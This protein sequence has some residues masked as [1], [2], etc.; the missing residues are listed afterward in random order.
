MKL[1]RGPIL[2][3]CFCCGCAPLASVKQVPARYAATGA[4]ELAVAEKELTEASQTE[5]RQ[6]ML[7][8]ADDLSGAKVAV[9]A[10]DRARD[11]ANAEKLY[12]FA[13]ARTVEII[14]RTQLAP[15]RRPTN[16]SDQFVLT[17]LRPPDP[18]HDPSNYNLFS[19]DALR[20]GGKFFE[21]RSSID[22]I[23]AP[24]VA[25][26]RSENPQ[27]R[28]RFEVPRVY[29]PTTAV[30]KFQGARAR[31]EFHEPFSSD[32][33]TIDNHSFPLAADYD[34]PMAMFLSRERPEKLGFIRLL[35][36]EKYADTARLTRLQPFDPGRTPVIFVH[37]LQETP[38]EWVPMISA[39]RK[40]PE[41]QRRYQLWVFSYPSGY[42]YPYSAALLRR[43]LDGIAHT[44]PNR[45]PIVLVGHSMGGLI[46][47]LMITDADDKIWRDLFGKSPRET[48][49]A[50]SSR[51]LLQ[52]AFVF[53]S[54]PEVKRVIFIST[55]HRGA[56]LA[57]SWIGRWVRKLI[58]AP[59]T[60][61]DARDAAIVL[62]TDDVAAKQLQR[63]PNSI[64]TLDPNDRFVQLINKIPLAP[65]IPYNS[66][67][68]DRGRPNSS[69]GVV[70]YWSSHLNGAQSEL[71][72]P[73][74]HHAEQASEGIAEVRRILKQ[75]P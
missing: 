20:L 35:L 51:D 30:L 16:V 39:L 38:A 73:A 57:S 13:V 28:Q 27:F 6:P 17:S 60:I 75:S 50:G 49:L 26:A 3:V 23:G 15:W 55:P 41:I 67:I 66:I 11:N 68:G 48:P 10:L 56:S 1:A 5:R 44:F 53:N 7:A 65:G 9:D 61:A 45:K 32:R 22:G 2:F 69:D 74:N 29:A 59:G 25:V 8:L 36:P 63:V 12:N 24:L 34:A 40:D 31:L 47:R 21:A 52:S 72:V 42:P 64:D 19:T 43:E 58:Q 37:G 70:P 4:Q 62:V 46:C 54:R 71:I 33:V 18:Q 14:Q